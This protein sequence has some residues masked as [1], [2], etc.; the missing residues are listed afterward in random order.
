MNQWR[1]LWTRGATYGLVASARHVSCFQ[2]EPVDYRT[3]PEK[4]KNYSVAWERAAV[5]QEVEH[6]TEDTA[7]GRSLCLGRICGRVGFR[8]AFLDDSHGRRPTLGETAKAR[9]PLRETAHEIV[10]IIKRCMSARLVNVCLSA[11]VELPRRHFGFVNNTMTSFTAI[12]QSVRMYSPC[13]RLGR[14][15]TLA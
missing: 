3:T 13:A 15:I 9:P 1:H 7:L 6:C 11:D 8:R 2:C 4:T 14:V 10:S 5:V 12:I